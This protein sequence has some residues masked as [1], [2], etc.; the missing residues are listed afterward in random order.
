MQ[1]SSNFDIT[2]FD[3]G[4]IMMP[5]FNIVAIEVFF[6]LPFIFDTKI[7]DFNIELKSDSSAPVVLNLD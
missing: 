6:W 1:I 5:S 3:S 7:D 2:V 4:K